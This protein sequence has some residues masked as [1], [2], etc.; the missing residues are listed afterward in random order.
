MIYVMIYFCCAERESEFCLHL[1]AYKKMIP[2]FFAGSHTN[3]ARDII[4]NLRMNVSVL[5][6]SNFKKV[7]WS[8]TKLHMD[9]F[10]DNNKLISIKKLNA[11]CHHTVAPSLV[12]LRT[13]SCYNSVPMMF[14]IGKSKTL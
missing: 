6:L 14:G 8:L 5:L 3:Y 4:V 12:A 10:T 9:I 11:S 2:Y 7:N 1:Y 13:L